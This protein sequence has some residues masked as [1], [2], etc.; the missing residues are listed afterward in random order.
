MSSGLSSRS[1][2]AS[3]NRADRAAVFLKIKPTSY[4][5]YADQPRGGARP[6]PAGTCSFRGDRKS[7]DGSRE[8][9]MLARAE[10]CSRERVLLAC[11]KP[12]R[13]PLFCSRAQIAVF[14]RAFPCSREQIGSQSRK[15]SGSC[16]Q[17]G[18]CELSGSCEQIGLCEQVKLAR[19]YQLARAR[20]ART[21]NLC[22]SQPP[23]SHGVVFSGTLSFDRLS[24]ARSPSPP[25]SLPQ[26]AQ[27]EGKKKGGGA[28]KRATTKSER[29]ERTSTAEQLRCRRG[30]EGKGQSLFERNEADTYCWVRR[31]VI[32]C[33]REGGRGGMVEEGEGVGGGGGRWWLVVGEGD[34][35]AKTEARARQAV[36]PFDL[37][38]LMRTQP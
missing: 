2:K 9:Y 1:P 5:T 22:S 13:E 14:V 6:F 26:A 32:E 38:I 33:T 12:L 23:P 25:P 11:L 17:N 37:Y 31:R 8:P 15:Q 7:A 4:P 27:R 34:E 29:V 16:E 30:G 18:S 3:C 28:D 35:T 24:P 19:A 20:S 36:K 21:S 10:K